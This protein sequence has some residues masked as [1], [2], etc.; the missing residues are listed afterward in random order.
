M[1]QETNSAVVPREMTVARWLFNPFIRIAGGQALAV[2]LTVIVASGLAAAAGG[3]HFDG[4]LD[5]HPGY[6]VS[7]WVPIVEGLVNW[8]AITVLL[9]L[10]SFLVAPRT[11]R[12]VDIA[13]TQAL[14]RFPLLLAA[15][16]CVPGPV[17]EANDELVAAAVEGRMA[18]PPAASVVAGL[19]VS[20]CAMWM[21]WLMWKAF[22][23]S[24]NQRG[25]QAVA[26]FVA[27]VF[28]GEV[29]TKFLVVQMLGGLAAAGVPGG[30]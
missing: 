6:R 1:P 9:V 22:A 5:F 25:W 17:R 10:V 24:C 3:V 14:A 13:G 28:A 7:F 18:T 2:G 20:S 15:L 16:A 29:A 23:V 4:L 27:A 26:I 21:V 8:S 30:S 11:V 12:V 19:F